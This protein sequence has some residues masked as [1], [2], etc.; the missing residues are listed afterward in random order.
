MSFGPVFKNKTSLEKHKAAMLILILQ[1]AN[2]FAFKN[3]KYEGKVLW[4]SERLSA[5]KVSD[6]I[7]DVRNKGLA[8]S[9]ISS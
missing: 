6:K 4:G 3:L 7:L 2:N 8:N 1:M 9:S 5:R